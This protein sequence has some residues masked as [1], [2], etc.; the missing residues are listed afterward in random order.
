MSSIVNTGRGTA[1]HI[2]DISSAEPKYDSFEDIIADVREGT[3]HSCLPLWG[4]Y[5]VWSTEEGH[6]EMT[7]TPK[8]AGI[9]QSG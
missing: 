9:N 6:K 4:K 8:R 2:F 7:Y 3:N 1:D 5:H